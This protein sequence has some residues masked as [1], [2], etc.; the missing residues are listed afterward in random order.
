MFIKKITDRIRRDFWAIY[1]CQF[2]GHETKG[3][4]YD[5]TNFHKNVIPDM[6][7]PQCKKS[8]NSHSTEN[9]K[10]PVL[11]PRYSDNVVV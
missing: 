4:G 11:E 6:K 3:D 9:N 2:C 10:P 1:E 7:C 8:T 5:D